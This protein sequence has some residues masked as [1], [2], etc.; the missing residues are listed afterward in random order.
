MSAPERE[1]GDVTEVPAAPQRRRSPRIRRAPDPLVGALAAAT[2]L[3]LLVQV[4][5]ALAGA[6]R[7]HPVTGSTLVT[8]VRT[9]AMAYEVRARTGGNVEI[10]VDASAFDLDPR[11]LHAYLGSIV[12][13]PGGD[14][15]QRRLAELAAAYARVQGHDLDALSVWRLDGRGTTSHPGRERVATWQP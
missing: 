5:A 10:P 12:V 11:Q 14:A 13:E 8:D 7:L 3:W 6:E 15:A 4:V 2:L 9:E 1:D